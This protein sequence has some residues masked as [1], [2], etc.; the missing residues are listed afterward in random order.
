MNKHKI[1]L[2]GGRG[3]STN[4]VFNSI[5][6]NLGITHAIIEDK[7]NIKLFLKRR[8][9][10]LGLFT[11]IGQILFQ[12]IIVK[13]LKFSSNKRY[14]EIIKEN[15]LDTTE[16]PF[17]K[18]KSVKSVNSKEVIA[19]LNDLKP[20]LIIV[21]GTRIISKKILTT[22]NCKFI[23]MHGGITP[24]Y[25]GAHGTYWALVNDDLENSGVTIHYVDEGID[26]GK[27]I[28]QS[29]VTPTNYDNF[30]TYPMLQLSEGLSLL[31]KSI[32][33]HFNNT[34]TTIE[35]PNIESGQYYHPTIWQYL[36]FRFIKGV[37]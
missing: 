16:I 8:I 11:V 30:Y 3:N 12:L 2:L 5:D 1:V 14:K 27:I 9:K 6:R 37:K 7:E 20:D 28:Y 26:T 33:Y 19:L 10:R 29:K 34:I 22:I 32:L 17:E 36:Y 25:R 13:Y 24:K 18:L 23:N 35:N 21:N 15:N 4:I 31:N